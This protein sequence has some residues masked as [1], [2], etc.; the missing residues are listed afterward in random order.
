MQ[1]ANAAR[2]EASR[3]VAEIGNIL[4]KETSLVSLEGNLRNKAKADH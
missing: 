1:V 4:A 3:R 2:G